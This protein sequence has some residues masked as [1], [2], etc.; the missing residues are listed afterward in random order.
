MTS[1]PRARW[2]HPSTHKIFKFMPDN[3]P[4]R[5]DRVLVDDARHRV[6]RCPLKWDGRTWRM[7]R[8]VKVRP[9]E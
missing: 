9:D 6:L 3:P 4:E 7:T 2:V 8:G 5:G 1:S